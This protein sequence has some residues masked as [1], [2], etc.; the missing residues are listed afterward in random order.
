MDVYAYLLYSDKSEN[1]KL[2]TLERLVDF[3]EVISNNTFMTKN[4]FF[5]YD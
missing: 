3:Y 1:D 4:E 2:S 5:S